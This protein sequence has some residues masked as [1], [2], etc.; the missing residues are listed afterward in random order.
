MRLSIT[1]GHFQ[2]RMF[3]INWVFLAIS[4]VWEGASILS[5]FSTDD[6]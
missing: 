1:L 5:S 6:G 3:L 2:I 4:D